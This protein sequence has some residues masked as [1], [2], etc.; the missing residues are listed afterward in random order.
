MAAFLFFSPLVFSYF[1][2]FCRDRDMAE[3]SKSG[4]SME[5]KGQVRESTDFLSMGLA[6]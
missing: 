3:E 5:V 1:Y 4:N 6:E 2:H